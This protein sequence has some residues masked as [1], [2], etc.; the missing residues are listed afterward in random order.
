MNPTRIK[1][2]LGGVP[3]DCLLRFPETAAWFADYQLPPGEPQSDPV[4]IPEEEW[5][6]FLELKLGE[7]P[8]TEYSAL[9]AFLSDALLSQNRVILHAAALRWQGRAILICGESGV[10]KSTQTAGLRRL[11]PGAF[12]VICGDRPILEH[13]SS[14]ERRGE[15]ERPTVLVHPSPWNGKEGWHDAEA[16]PLGGIVLLSRG[17]ENRIAPARNVAAAVRLYASFIQSS[18]REQNIRSLAELATEL[19][20]NF[21]VWTLESARVPDSTALLLETL[22]SAPWPEE[23][24]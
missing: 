24:K 3:V 9:T 1:L 6:S 4:M 21:P 18:I 22:E 10:G 11:R 13:P 19:V 17:P 23:Q 5:E 14:W 16:A 20:K 15:S 12:G 7:L 8:Y 2:M